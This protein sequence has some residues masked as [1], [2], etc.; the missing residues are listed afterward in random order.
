[1]SEG[2]EEIEIQNPLNSGIIKVIKS[3]NNCVYKRSILTKSGRNP[4]YETVCTNVKDHI[5][6]YQSVLY[7]NVYGYYEP[8]GLD[9]EICPFHQQIIR[10]KALNRILNENNK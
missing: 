3:C 6:F 9:G 7:K 5:R 1:M 4:E 10:E 2:Y 8:P